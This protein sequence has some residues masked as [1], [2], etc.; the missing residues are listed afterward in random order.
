MKTSTLIKFIVVSNIVIGLMACV[1]PPSEQEQMEKKSDQQQSNEQQSNEQQSPQSLPSSP[2]S[3]PASAVSSTDDEIDSSRNI[4]AADH[5][6]QDGINLYSKGQYADAI[7]KLKS[8]DISKGGAAYRVSALKYLAFS[9]CVTNQSQ[10][11]ERA[12]RDALRI[13]PKFNLQ[14]SEK[15]HP[16]WG[17]VFQKAQSDSS[18][19]S[20]HPR[21]PASNPE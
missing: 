4:L 7:K 20:R 3:A 2:A 15:N 10:A 18:K 21:K 6:L 1:T 12:F 5:A 14:R 16:I 19:R 11:C 13:D 17:P 9:Y 8:P